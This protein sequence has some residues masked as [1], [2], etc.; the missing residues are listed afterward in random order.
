MFRKTEQHIG[1]IIREYIRE[2]GLETPLLQ[3]RLIDS[4]P[5][6]LGERIA[7]YITDAS[8]RNQVLWLHVSA[9]ALRSDLMMMRTNLVKHLNKEVN[10]LIIT[11]I[12]IN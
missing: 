9:P 6:V 1:G 4:L 3:K 10:A 7:G 5:K 2:E 12:K 11:D 8:I